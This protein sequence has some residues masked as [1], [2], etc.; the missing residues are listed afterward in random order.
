MLHADVDVDVMTDVTLA[1]RVPSEGLF[2]SRFPASPLPLRCVPFEILSFIVDESKF[3]PAALKSF[4]VLRLLR[5]LKLVR[6]C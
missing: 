4:K 6:L 1:R 2:F 3:P 5:L